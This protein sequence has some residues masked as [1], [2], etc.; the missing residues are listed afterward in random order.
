MQEIGPARAL[1]DGRAFGRQDPSLLSSSVAL[2]NGGVGDCCTHLDLAWHDL[3]AR[4]SSL[5][6]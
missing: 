2:E 3:A 4:F 6:S 5:S 1:I